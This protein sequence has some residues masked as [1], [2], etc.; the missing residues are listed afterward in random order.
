[1]ANTPTEN[2]QDLIPYVLSILTLAA[3][4]DVR[5]YNVSMDGLGRIDFFTG[6][7]SVRESLAGL[8]SMPEEVLS[9]G[10]CKF[11]QGDDNGVCVRVWGG[12]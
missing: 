9:S 3:R 6:D 4:N 12:R 7:A 5:I 10:E 8:L 1:M 11:R 2:L